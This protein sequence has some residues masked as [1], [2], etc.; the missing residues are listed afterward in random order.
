[1]KNSLGFPEST[2]LSDQELPQEILDFIR[3][4]EGF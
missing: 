2:N 3:F 4:Y 1:M